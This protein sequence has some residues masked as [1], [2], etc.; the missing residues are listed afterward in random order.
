L[1]AKKHNAHVGNNCSLEAIIL[2]VFATEYPEGASE[3]LQLLAEEKDRASQQLKKYSQ[4]KAAS[5]V[6]A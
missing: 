5:P 2:K 3:L 4:Q 1:T 6:M